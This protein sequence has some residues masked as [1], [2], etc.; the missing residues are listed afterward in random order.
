MR[1][2][3]RYHDGEISLTEDLAEN[4]MLPPYAILSHTW[5]AD[6]DEV[7]FGDFDEGTGKHKPGY[8]KILF[9]AEQAMKDGLHHFWIDTCCIDKA[10]KAEY[11]HAIS[12]MF[13]WYRNAARCY[14]YLSDV[15]S[16]SAIS[17][18][19]RKRKRD[20]PMQSSRSEPVR[21][22]SETPSPPQWEADLRKS[23]WFTRGWTLQELLGP[24]SIEFFS[25]DCMR[26][27]DKYSLEQLI[28]Q[29]TGIPRS[30]LRGTPLCQFHIKDR[31]RWI[32]SRETKLEEDRAY[33]LQGIFDVEIPLRYGEGMANAFK[34]LED[35][36]DKVSTCIQDICLTDPR[37]DRKRIEDTKGGL[38][39]ASY[40]W[41]LDNPDFRQWREA[42][43]SRL[44]WIKGDP[45]KGKTM[46][47]CGIIKEL[48]KSIPKTELLSY[49]FCQATDSQINSAVAALRGLLYMLVNQQPSL[50]SHVQKQTRAG[51]SSYEGTNAWIV[52]SNIFTDIL[53]DPSLNLTYLLVDALDECVH[54]Q[55]KLLDF[56]V[57]KSTISTHVK[58]I[59]TSRNHANIEQK[60]LLDDSGTR[61]SLEIKG[62]AEHV[63]RAVHAYI[64]YRLAELPYLQQNLLL[65]SS[66][67]KKM[68]LKANG[69]FLWVSL[70]MKEIQ[71]A[72]EW[73][74]LTLLD[75]VP[76]ELKEIYQRMLNQIS[77]LKRQYPDLCRT[78]LATVI[79]TYRPL[80]L[81]EL[82]VLSK[83]PGR[84]FDIVQTVENIVKM[85][86]SFLTIR[87]G[88][89]YVI[90]QS[91]SD[92]L[93][94]EAY[95]NIFPSGVGDT[96]QLVVHQ[97]IQIMLKTLR[98]NMFDLDS[99]GCPIEEV[100]Q[101]DP[102]P[103]ITSR[104]SCSYWIDHLC[105]WYHKSPVFTNSALRIKDI[106]G[107]F[108]KKNFL[109]WL[110]ALSLCKI[111]PKGVSS[112]EKLEG[113]VQVI[114]GYLYCRT[115]ENA[116]CI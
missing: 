80:H 47:L 84:E 115:S 43:R 14:V 116:N 99:L 1:L 104:Y 92:F 105:E 46:L 41:I 79:A 20:M 52:L 111:M 21:S 69:S 35:E 3:K 38:L 26:L 22:G 77:T 57:Q 59:L 44:L 95:S 72:L 86:G 66:I 68:L 6:N 7:T 85:C 100:K 74:I 28:H 97:S 2:L 106:I 19:T 12:S 107:S 55:A 33:S 11:S 90:H 71:D 24:A 83:L 8:E 4:G 109:Y 54:D 23:R 113:L 45:G 31:F 53:Q 96:H 51:R 63:S 91:A 93:Q 60:L 82:G 65:Q 13:R 17:K 32:E 88:I 61:L 27:G 34:R 42:D 110:E 25:R 89:V 102:D 64:E 98:R 50:V 48:E 40:Q 78:V 39:D 36:I 103:L 49:F 76:M 18:E 37:D 9:C 70:V 10:N 58:W 81:R 30:A 94:E 75:E 29:V 15:S 16:I 112:M 56:I 101:P 114:F 108:L 5:G 62:N 73:E 67:Q 87:E